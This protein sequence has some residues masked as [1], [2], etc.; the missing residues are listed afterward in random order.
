MAIIPNTRHL[1]RYKDIAL[2]FAKYGHGDLLSGSEFFDDT[3]AHRAPPPAPPKAEELA[4]DLEEL[5]PTFIKLG[6]LLSTRAD[7]LPP[8]YMQALS[9]L[10]DKV[11]PFPFDEVE[12]IVPVELGIRLSKAFS[13]FERE[14]MAAASLGQVHRA[15]LRGGR[16]VAVKVQRPNVREKMMDDL[17]ALSEI[18]DFLDAHT[19][20]G[21]RYEFTKLIEQ[22]RKSLLSE[23]DY[24]QEAQHLRVLREHLKAFDRIVVPAPID[25]YT[26]SRLLTM[27]YITGRKITALSPLV[28]LE[29]NGGELAEQLFKAYLQQILVD[30][31]FHA[32]PHPG[33]IFLTDD[34]RVALIDLGMVGRIAPKM[35][36]YLLQLLLAISEGRSDDAATIAVKIGDPKDDFNEIE[37]RQQIGEIVMQQ[38]DATVEQMQ[39]GRVVLDVN[40]VAANCRIRVPTEL[41]MLGK[42]L[43]NLDLIGRALDANFN[44][45]E[46]I[47]RNAGE[48][49]RQRMMKSLSPGNLFGGLLE[50]KDFVERLPERANRILDSVANNNLR[51]KVDTIDEQTFMAGLQKIANRITVGLIIASL[52]ISAS[53]LMHVQTNFR[54]FG[55]PGLPMIFFLLAAGAGILLI[56][57][58]LTRD[59]EKKK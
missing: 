18:A 43:L 15:A 5:G 32:D 25:D 26:T 24:R 13:H 35:Q 8:A 31:F 52:I 49:L 2:L 27:E 16:E 46:S 14:P 41:S 51:I 57:S 44:P 40:L 12:A 50:V 19:E 4:N 48:M 36:E 59:V 29:I 53:Q 34:H 33:N 7:F 6:Q 37:F 23:L 38:K 56:F 20:A 45:N 11:G 1:A 39:V 28:R 3:L 10:Q 47:R 30:G 42:T 54:L 55:Y 17:D 22:F 21:R 9:R 58:I